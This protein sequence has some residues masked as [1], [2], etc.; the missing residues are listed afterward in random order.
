MLDEVTDTI[1]AT[2]ASGYGGR[3]RKA[4]RKR[5]VEQQNFQVFDYFTRG[6]DL[7]ER[8]NKEDNRH[9]RVFLGERSGGTGPLLQQSNRKAC[10]VTY[11]RCHLWL[12]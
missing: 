5:D 6:I 8:F 1:V 11:A 7:A 12:G 2:L 10:L 4:S 9:S 3:L